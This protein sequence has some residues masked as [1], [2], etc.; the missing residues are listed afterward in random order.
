MTDGRASDGP[1]AP[2]NAARHPHPTRIRQR[3]ATQRARLLP[4]RPPIPD[5]AR[6]QRV[7]RK[8]DRPAGQWRTQPG[9]NGGS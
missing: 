5:G 2:P 9:A 4:A 3:S 6:R 7:L 8:V 1:S